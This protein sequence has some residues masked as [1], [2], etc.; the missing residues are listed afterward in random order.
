MSSNVLYGP[1]KMYRK[2][3]NNVNIVGHGSSGVGLQKNLNETDLLFGYL[4]HHLK[5]TLFQYL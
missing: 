2:K 5:M 3:F 4:N 1:P